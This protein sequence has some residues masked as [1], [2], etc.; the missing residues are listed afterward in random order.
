MRLVLFVVVTI[1]RVP[2]FGAIM[3][4]SDR[5]G[6]FLGSDLSL[7]FGHSMASMC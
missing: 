3:T 7:L 6:M 2:A 5:F 1:R 4:D